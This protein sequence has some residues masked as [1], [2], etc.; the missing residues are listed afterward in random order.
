LIIDNSPCVP[1][2]HVKT[3]IDDYHWYN[4]IPGSYYNWVDFVSR[5]VKDPSWTFG[6][7]PVR[8]GDEPLLVSEFGVWGLPSLLNIT[9][10]YSEIEK[11]PG[12]PWWFNK[13]WGS[14][15]PLGARER[16]NSWNL[17]EV[18]KDWE[19]FAAFSQWHQFEA[20]K[21]MIE[22]MRKYPQI[23]G[24]IITE[25]YD[26]H[27]ECNGLLDFYRNPKAYFNNLSGVNNDDLLILDRART[28][29]NLWSG[30]SFTVPLYFSKWSGGELSN[31]KLRWKLEDI[32]KGE[33]VDIN[34]LP[35]D[36]TNLGSI[37]FTA[38]D[39]AELT[40]LTLTAE[41]VDSNNNVVASNYINI[42]VSPKN[43][44][45]EISKETVL[46]YLPHPIDPTLETAVREYVR[47]AQDLGYNVTISEKID[48][49]VSCVVS[50]VYDDEVKDYVKKGGKVLVIATS[51][52]NLN[53]DGKLYRVDRRGGEWVTDFHYIR[54]KKILEGLPI[55]NPLG[56]SYY[57]T[58]PDLVIENV[59]PAELE[60]VY[61]GYFEGWIHQH[62]AT[63]FKKETD[64]GG[65]IVIST[66]KFDNYGEDPVTTIL[67]G[68]ILKELIES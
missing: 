23:T 62:A 5:Y 11:N 47:R 33:I 10:G 17:S 66:F 64:S 1:N 8:K 55:E 65:A 9:K 49:K 22:E 45:S 41:L 59:S 48:K 46:V 32:L 21:F 39:V 42:I 50:F 7:N 68:N 61:A 16:F 38:P 26:L 52:Q 35:Y 31:M 44:S 36:V 27:W 18:W 43:L 20:L 14:G 29:T 58:M 15:V 40:K 37:S 51:P 6:N 60:S 67:L 3:D 28:R 12:E 30:E 53:V 57:L 56:W 4:T 2:Y 24:Y 25:F 19:E 34:I 54:N 13:G 63:I